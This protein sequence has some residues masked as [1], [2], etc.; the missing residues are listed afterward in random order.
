[1]KLIQ[2]TKVFSKGIQFRDHAGFAVIVKRF[3]CNKLG[4]GERGLVG[5]VAGWE[6]QTLERRMAG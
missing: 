2:I 6:L 5:F 4:M 1:M 3:H